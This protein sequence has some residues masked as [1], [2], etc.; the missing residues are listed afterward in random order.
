[1]AEKEKK[2]KVFLATSHGY[3]LQPYFFYSL[4]RP[5]RFRIFLTNY[6]HKQIWTKGKEKLAGL[7]LNSFI[8][9][10]TMDT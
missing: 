8:H 3:C 5:Q 6:Q 7:V 1:M 10:S 9:F 4:S 2:K